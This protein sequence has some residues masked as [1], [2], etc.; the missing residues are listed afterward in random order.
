LVEFARNDSAAMPFSL[1]IISLLA[2]VLTHTNTPCAARR[3]CKRGIGVH[4]TYHEQRGC[5]VHAQLAPA[6]RGLVALPR[7]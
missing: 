3:E 5:A 4:H 1:R 6:A 2:S 7:R